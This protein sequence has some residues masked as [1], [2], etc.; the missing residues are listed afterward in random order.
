M[1]I[2]QL[3]GGLGNQMFQY[4]LG[5]VLSIKLNTKLLFD[6]SHFD[7][8][9]YTDTKRSYDL[10]IFNLPGVVADK[11]ILDKM[12]RPNRYKVVLNKYLNLGLDP[13]PKNYIKEN[14]HG[15][16]PQILDTPDNSYLSGFWQSEK[17]FIDHRTTL[18]K[19]YSSRSTPISA[20]NKKLSNIITQSNCVSLHVRR[21]DYITNSE[22][23]AFHGV[24]DLDYY[25]RAM[26]YIEN[27]TKN[28]T[29]IVFSDDP[30]WT[31]ANIKSKHKLIH[32]SHNT[33]HAAHED[34]RLMSLCTHNIIANS[35]FSWWGA[36]LN[37]NPKRVVISPRRWFNTNQID[38]KDL[39]PK[40][41]IK[42]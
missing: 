23:N 19:D 2:T 15:F 21:S 34:I 8:Q 42:L 41:W 18:V 6:I 37:T 40:N 3:S 10:G 5:R 33:G 13:Y 7:Y 29:Y 36:W 39:I 35:T 12:G 4:A 32:V 9:P 16:N 24:C 17:Y 14:G 11:P 31:K 28:P 22:A 26:S 30:D 1:I 25:G 20:K 27:I 38:T